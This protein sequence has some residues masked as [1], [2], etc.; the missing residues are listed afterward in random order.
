MFA[1]IDLWPG[2]CDSFFLTLLFHKACSLMMLKTK[3][4][5][6]KIYIV[7]VMLWL[8]EK[9]SLPSLYQQWLQNITILMYKVKH[10]LVPTYLTEIVNIRNADFNIPHFCAGHFGPHLW[11][12]LDYSDR[13]KPNIKSFENSIKNKD[14]TLL[15]DKCNKC[16]ICC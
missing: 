16:D 10:R 8:A 4:L 5:P 14:L 9:A 7:V 1:V 6:W 3:V 11:N 13:E 12:K 15:K 2:S